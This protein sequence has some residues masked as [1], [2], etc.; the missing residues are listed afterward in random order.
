MKTGHSNKISKK[1]ENVH[2]PFLPVFEKRS[3]MSLSHSDKFSKKGGKC[4]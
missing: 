1:G 4:P 3:K 2:M